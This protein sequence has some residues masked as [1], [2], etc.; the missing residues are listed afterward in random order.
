MRR[1]KIPE[2]IRIGCYDYKVQVRT[3]VESIG[4]ANVGEFSPRE[5]LIVV[6]TQM[7]PIYSLNTLIH[8]I[9]HAIMYVE[10]TSHTE[11]WSNEYI[12]NLMANAWVQIYRDNPELLKYIVETSKCK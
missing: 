3:N 7:D 4:N 10:S 8:E 9:N 12:V 1:P 2:S 6:N 5:V 11:D